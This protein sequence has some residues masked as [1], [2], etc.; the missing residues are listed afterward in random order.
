M[1]A[2]IYILFI[3]YNMH[4]IRCHICDKQLVKNG[5][6]MCI[7]KSCDYYLW[8]VRCH[9]KTHYNDT[10]CNPTNFIDSCNNQ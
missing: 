6:T 8:C 10:I 2:F 9:D 4:D 5:R 7:I 1:N 3:S